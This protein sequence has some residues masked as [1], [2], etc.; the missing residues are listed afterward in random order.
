MGLHDLVRWKYVYHYGTSISSVVGHKAYCFISDN[1]GSDC[2]SRCVTLSIILLVIQLCN[3]KLLYFRAHI[4]GL[5]VPV[6]NLR[7]LFIFLL[8]YKRLYICLGLFVCPS[9][10]QQNYSKGLDKFPSNI[11][12]RYALDKNSRLDFRSE[13]SE[14]ALHYCYLSDCISFTDEPDFDTVSRFNI[15]K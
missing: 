7:L 8:P 11:L 10:C 3:I 2:L 15:A 4:S 12:E 6:L 9:V 13:I 1:D 5:F 14:T